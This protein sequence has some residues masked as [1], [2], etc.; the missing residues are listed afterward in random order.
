MKPMVEA[1]LKG[2]KTDDCERIVALLIIVYRLR[3]N[4]FHGQKWTGDQL[5]RQ[6]DNFTH[7]NGILMSALEIA[8]DGPDTIWN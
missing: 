1:V 3:N 5:G 2:E 7:A 4:L 6:F 8:R